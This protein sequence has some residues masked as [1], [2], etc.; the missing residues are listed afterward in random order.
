MA[1]ALRIIGAAAGVVA[2]VATGLGGLGVVAIA[3]AKLAT[4]ASIAG[5]IS[6]AASIAT[7]AL[8][9]PPAAQGQVNDRILGANNPLP[10]LMGRAYTGGVQVHDVGYGG[11]VSDVQNPYRFIVTV[12]SCAGPILSVGPTLANWTE[13]PFSGNAA[14]GYYSGFWYRDTQLGQKPESSALSAHFGSPPRWGT[15]YKL[16]G[17]AA[18]SH[19]LKLDKK[20]VRFGGGQLPVFGN[21][22]E[23]V[24]VYDPRLDS[25]VPGGS[26]SHRIDDESTWSY[27]RRPALHALAYAYGRFANGKKIFGV[28]WLIG[29]ID[30]ANIIAWANVCDA[31]DWNVDGV[32]YEPGDKWANLKRIAQAGG[33]RPVL[34]GG[35]LRFDY[36]APRTSLGRVELEDLAGGT[37]SDQS[38]RRWKQRHNTILPRYR[39]EAHQWEY[40]QSDPVSVAAFVTEDGEEKLD[41]VQYDLVTDKDQAAQ[42]A[43][44][45]LWQR[46]ERGPFSRVLKP[47]MKIWEIGDPLTIAASHSPTG[48]DLEVVM[49]DRTIDPMTGQINA[50]F[51]GES[52]AKHVDALGATGTAPTTITLP[53]AEELDALIAINATGA[54]ELGALIT[55]RAMV[56]VDPPDGMIQATDA[57]ITVEGHTA[58]YFDKNVSVTGTTLTTEDDGTT[59]IAPETRYHL[60]YDDAARVG[61]AVD[62]KA[63]QGITQAVNSA[64]NPGR[65]YVGSITTDVVG[66]SG[67]Q[68]GGASPPYVNR[69]DWVDGS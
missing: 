7:R 17:M 23:G 58:E 10:Y 34:T 13:V 40:V 32:I 26:G 30:I 9:R 49:T 59:A 27:S 41:E 67:V 37:L 39:S 46:R 48:G 12:L 68:G 47:H 24:M 20:G 66:G 43:L 55:G 57:S 22:P 61:G 69:P 5:G 33:A 28:D 18:V 65:H 14:T 38:G 44:Y 19:N 50:V 54:G 1:K 29:G 8:N 36:F 45:E 21:V 25:T 64:A 31:N 16:S 60:Y 11:E 56:D 51:E 62:I 15:S 42:L 35:R 6:I 2:L 63:T 4:V 53:T 52:A 3:G